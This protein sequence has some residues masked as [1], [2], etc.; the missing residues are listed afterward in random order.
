MQG[1][2][3]FFKTA[4]L[5]LLLLKTQSIKMKKLVILIM[6]IAIVVAFYEQT[7]ADK[8]VYVSV[9]AMAVFMFGM[10]RL[11]AKTPSKNP[12]KEEEDV[13]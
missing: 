2:V 6:L 13:D 1:K 8:N 3:A 11:S 9:I 7:T 5:N 12:E 10:M 4:I